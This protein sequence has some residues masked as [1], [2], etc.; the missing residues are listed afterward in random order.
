MTQ[1]EDFF[2][3]SE[4]AIRLFVCEMDPR[5]SQR[6]AKPVLLVHGARVPGLASFDL[7]VPHG[8]LAEDLANAGHAVYVM[9]ARGY[10]RRRG[11]RR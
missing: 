3:D 2:V 10:G 5:P 9:D 11:L 4:A 8:S 1:R 6:G 7:P